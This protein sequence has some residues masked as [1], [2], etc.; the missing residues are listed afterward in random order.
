MKLLL[1]RSFQSSVLFSTMRRS[2]PRAMRRVAHLCFNNSIRLLIFSQIPHLPGGRQGF[3]QKSLS[4]NIRVIC[5]PFAIQ[6]FIS[7]KDRKD[8]I[9]RRKEI[10]CALAKTQRLCVENTFRSGNILELGGL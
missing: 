2:L 7:R 3:T 10:L 1:R 8:K 4:V 5:E 9:R 6:L